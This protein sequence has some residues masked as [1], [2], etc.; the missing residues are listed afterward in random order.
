M[1][2]QW[3]QKVKPRCPQRQSALDTHSTDFA[4]FPILFPHF[5]GSA[6]NKLPALKSLLQDLLFREFKLSARGV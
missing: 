4:P 2:S 3:A 6:L 5:L 1:V